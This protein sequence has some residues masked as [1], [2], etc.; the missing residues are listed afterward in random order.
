MYVCANYHLCQARGMLVRTIE[1]R[2]YTIKAGV[3]SAWLFL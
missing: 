3:G 1:L 2:S